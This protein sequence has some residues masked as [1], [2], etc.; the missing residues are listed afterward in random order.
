M[1]ITEGNRKRQNETAEKIKGT[2]N[3]F[4]FQAALCLEPIHGPPFPEDS[5]FFQSRIV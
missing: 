4:L 1:L 3:G 5:V 2:N